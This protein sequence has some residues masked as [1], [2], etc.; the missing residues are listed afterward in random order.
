MVERKYGSIQ[1][2]TLSNY[3]DLDRVPP[4]Q[5]Q[6]G[7]IRHLEAFCAEHGL[8]WGS[9]NLRDGA[10]DGLHVNITFTK[11]IAGLADDE[12]EDAADAMGYLL[13]ERI[14]DCNYFTRTMLPNG[15]YEIEG[16]DLRIG[17]DT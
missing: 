2:L 17:Y 16:T 12:V 11:A 15:C 5:G 1:R 9:P 13:L 14:F 3:V 10:F 8:A 6:E 7:V 4:G